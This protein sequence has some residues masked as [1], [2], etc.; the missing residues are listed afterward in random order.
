MKNKKD[1]MTNKHGVI[2]NPEYEILNFPKSYKFKMY[3]TVANTV[4]GRLR[5]LAKKYWT[6]SYKKTSRT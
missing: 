2:T 1:Y 6:Q 4:K 5:W 3:F